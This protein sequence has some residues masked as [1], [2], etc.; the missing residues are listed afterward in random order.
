M[1]D[2]GKVVKKMAAAAKKRKEEEDRRVVGEL[3]EM[4]TPMLHK[5]LT[6]QG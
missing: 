4:V 3:T 5:A 1:E 2:M 6:K